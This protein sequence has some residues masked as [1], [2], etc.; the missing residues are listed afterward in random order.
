MENMVETPKKMN[1][2]KMRFMKDYGFMSME[3]NKEVGATFRIHTKKGCWVEVYQSKN[4]NEK[5]V[6]VC[7]TGPLDTLAT[8]DFMGVMHQAE[9]M[10]KLDWRK[11][12]LF[13][14]ENPPTYADMHGSKS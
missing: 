8:N 10:L 14:K 3:G 1:M 4:Q 7:A 9:S 13:V 2:G 11:F 5:T 6:N 12:K